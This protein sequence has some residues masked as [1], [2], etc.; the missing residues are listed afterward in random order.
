VERLG[1]TGEPAWF[2]TLNRDKQRPAWFFAREQGVLVGYLSVFDPLGEALEVSAFVAPGHRRR[3]V[4]TGLLAEARRVW[5]PGRRWLLVVDREAEGR[6]LAS[7][8]GTLSFT[9]YTLVLPA[10]DRPVFPGLEDGLTLVSAAAEHLDSAAGVLQAAGGASDARAFLDSVVTDPSRHLLLL[11]E[12][13]RTVGTAGVHR[14]GDQAQLFALAIHPSHQGRGRGRALVL[15]ALE[16]NAPG[17]REFTL[18]VD[19][20]NPR[21][22]GLYRRLGFQDRTATDYYELTPVPSF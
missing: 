12:D 3:G 16:L 21:A 11:Q 19:T 22:E 6:G 17:V 4:F 2:T 10:A 18:E 9:E 7:R 1:D 15:A 5:G 8:L 20:A 13:G 14:D